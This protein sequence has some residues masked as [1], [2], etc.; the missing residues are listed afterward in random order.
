M[1]SKQK[2]IGGAVQSKIIDE[3]LTKIKEY[4][5]RHPESGRFPKRLRNLILRALSQGVSSNKLG[6]A[7]GLSGR[8]IRYWQKSDAVLKKARSKSP[9]AFK[10]S[11][12]AKRSRKN[13]FTKFRLKPRELAVVSDVESLLPA[14]NESQVLSRV[15]VFLRSGVKLELD[16]SALSSDFLLR[17]SEIGEASC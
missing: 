1:R 17:L 15:S 16:L 14:E 2:Q 9:K 11:V 4:R 6:R 7:I 5:E 10:N 8:A 12:R 13:K 3:A